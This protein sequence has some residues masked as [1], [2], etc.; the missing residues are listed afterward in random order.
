MK[1]NDKW[2]EMLFSVLGRILRSNS[3][4]HEYHVVNTKGEWKGYPS[5]D[6]EYYGQMYSVVLIPHDNRASVGRLPIPKTNWTEYLPMEANAKR[7][8]VG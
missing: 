7:A 5:V 1:M 8:R 4:T 3:K 6:V 2:F